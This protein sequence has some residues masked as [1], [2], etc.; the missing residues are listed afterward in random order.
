MKKRAVIFDMDGVISDTQKFH[1][2][3]ESL[4]L[5]DLNILI[6]PKE[7]SQKYAG[8]TDERMF[9]ELLKKHGINV[10]VVKDIV[11]KKWAL[12]QEFATGKIKPIPHAVPLI[13]TLKEA[14]FKLAIAS[15][16]TMSFIN[17]VVIDL[18]ISR[19]FDAIVSAQEVKHG[20]PA[21]DVFLLAA[22][23]LGVKP[24][25]VVVIEDGRSGMMGATAAHM[26]SIG[27][28]SNIAEDYP[29]TKLVSSLNEITV[30]MI[31]QL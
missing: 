10:E 27:L 16:S 24:E 17:E 1:S 15:A 23:R 6:K 25:A 7:I 3:V 8:V 9:A 28:V 11:L 22:Q 2:T 31:H 21:P 20:K 19:Y 26:K 29:A 13:R 14:H 12:M 5:K 4:I 18:H 30:E